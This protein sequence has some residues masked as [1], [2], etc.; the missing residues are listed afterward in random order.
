[1]IRWLIELWILRWIIRLFMGL[2]GR[3]VFFAALL[4]FLKFVSEHTDTLLYWL[5]LIV[6]AAMDKLR[7][8]GLTQML[9]MAMAQELHIH[10][11]DNTYA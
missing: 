11:G 10:M 8:M 2:L 5:Q 7:A 3:I 6:D 9:S 1:M 4:L